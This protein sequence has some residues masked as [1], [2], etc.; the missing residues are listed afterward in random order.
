MVDV[1]HH[2]SCAID[3]A[4]I[5]I[6]ISITIAISPPPPPSSDTSSGKLG[7]IND[8][9]PLLS[10]SSMVSIKMGKRYMDQVIY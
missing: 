4:P 2:R 1:S 9:T 10:S 3:H 6:I 5:A 8:A 7:S